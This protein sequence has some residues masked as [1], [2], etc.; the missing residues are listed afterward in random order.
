MRLLGELYS[1]S[2]E[3]DLLCPH[4][5]MT[6]WSPDPS[7]EEILLLWRGCWTLQRNVARSVTSFFFPPGSNVV[8]RLCFEEGLQVSVKRSKALFAVRLI[9]TGQSK[10]L[11]WCS[12]EASL[13]NKVSQV[14]T[15]SDPLMS[16]TC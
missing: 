5:I 14:Q 1:R 10:V 7:A 8:K 15:I 6:S 2:A 4:F 16:L 12:K 11:F 3:V 9:G 13:V